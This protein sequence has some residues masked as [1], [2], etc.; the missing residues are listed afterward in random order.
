MMI[1]FYIILLGV[2]FI[3]ALAVKPRRVEGFYKFTSYVL[4]AYQIFVTVLIFT[5][6]L[7]STDTE[8]FIPA[9]AAGIGS[10]AF[11]VLINCQIFT[12]LRGAVHY[13]FLVPTYVNVF[14]IYS[15]CNIHDCTWGNRP[16]SLSAEEKERIEEFEEFR[17]RWA[18]LWLLSNSSLMYYFL[19]V[20]DIGNPNSDSYYALLL[21]AGFGFVVLVIRLF[22]GIIYLI[23]ESCK[24]SINEKHEI[25]INPAIRASTYSVVFK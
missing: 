10:F 14:F 25:V 15:I 13:L 21:V 19:V 12:I 8:I 20:S 11:I 16:D 5:F 4:G 22:G 9:Y 3:E 24:K 6:V 23:S 18:L 1:L 7:A 17:T 2:L